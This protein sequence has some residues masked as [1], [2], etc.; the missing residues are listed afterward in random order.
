[1]PKHEHIIE[2][3]RSHD[4]VAVLRINPRILNLTETNLRS[5]CVVSRFAVNITARIVSWVQG[6]HSIDLLFVGF[7]S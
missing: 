7:S 3:P 4:S 2:K 5:T 1:L 6:D